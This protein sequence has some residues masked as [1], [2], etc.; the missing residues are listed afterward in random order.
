MQDAYKWWD[1]F[2]EIMGVS[3][4]RAPSPW[5]VLSLVA[6]QPGPDRLRTVP[7]KVEIATTLG[8]DD[9]EVE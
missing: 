6:R 7:E 9:G 8:H 1:A 3:E 4:E 2:D 5:D